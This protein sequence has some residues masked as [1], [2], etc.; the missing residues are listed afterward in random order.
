MELDRGS[1]TTLEHIENAAQ[2]IDLMLEGLSSE[3][4]EVKIAAIRFSVMTIIELTASLK[5]E[6]LESQGP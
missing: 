5:P 4:D 3:V 2:G 1:R 6:T